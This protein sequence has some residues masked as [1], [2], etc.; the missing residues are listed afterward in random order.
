MM[1]LNEFNHLPG[2]NEEAQKKLDTGKVVVLGATASG[3]AAAKSLIQLGLGNLLVVDKEAI[4]LSV[5]AEELHDLTEEFPEANVL[6]LKEELKANTLEGLVQKNDVIID[7]LADWQ[8]KLLASDLCMSV[9]RPLIHSGVTGFRM[10]IYAMLP[11]KSACLRCALPLA[12]IDDVPHK[13][14]SPIGI[15]AV[16]QMV[17]SWQAIETVKLIAQI[18]ATQGNELFK[19]DSLSGEF[20]IIRGL[21][22]QLDC[23]DCGTVR[24]KK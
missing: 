11:K 17:G 4:T 16:A 5:A 22:P 12:G 7:A 1:V 9:G 13:P 15:S 18:G 14:P 8:D 21:D 23:P 24:R 6:I 19:F 3:L 10:Q 20:E 2:L